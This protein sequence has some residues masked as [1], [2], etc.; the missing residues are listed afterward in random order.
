MS[1]TVA[2]IILEQL[3]GRR[4]SILTGSK[5]FVGGENHLS[6]QIGRNPKKVTHCKITLEPTDTYRVQ[7]LRFNRKTLDTAVLKDI[8]MVHV[9][10]LQDIFTANTGLYTHL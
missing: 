8:Q 3:G 5:H 2:N 4:F 10:Q 6:F 7:F 1:L 9:D